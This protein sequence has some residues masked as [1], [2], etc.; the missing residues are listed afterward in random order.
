MIRSESYKVKAMLTEQILL[1]SIYY[2][3]RTSG[4]VASFVSRTEPSLE[5]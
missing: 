5:K 4:R 2:R 1:I 3:V